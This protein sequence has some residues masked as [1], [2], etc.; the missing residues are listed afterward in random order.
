[1]RRSTLLI[2][3]DIWHREIRRKNDNDNVLRFCFEIPFARVM[4][5][6]DNL[7]TN[8]KKY[9][10]YDVSICQ[11][12]RISAE[13][14]IKSNDEPAIIIERRYTDFRTLYDGLR[15]D[16]APLL[17]GVQFPKKVL[18]GNFSSDLI[19]DRSGM[20]EMFLDHIVASSVLRESMEFLNFLQAKELSKACQLLDERRNEQAVPIL[21]NCFRLLNKV[22]WIANKIKRGAWMRN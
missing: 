16:H 8:V 6:L 7:N 20:F 9:I 3:I 19:A 15:K 12:T 1:M 13:N 5:T 10:I 17:A 4:P 11:D 21:E 22:S 2:S 14:S 18:M